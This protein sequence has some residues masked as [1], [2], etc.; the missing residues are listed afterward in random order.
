MYG[1]SLQP[2]FTRVSDVHSHHVKKLQ[3]IVE[4]QLFTSPEGRTPPGQGSP[5]LTIL[6]GEAWD[7]WE[8]IL[9]YAHEIIEQNTGDVIIGIVNSKAR[10]GQYINF[11]A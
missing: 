9:A 8:D 2:D 6:E 1:L 4:N 3:L 11:Q 5:F 10:G 7:L